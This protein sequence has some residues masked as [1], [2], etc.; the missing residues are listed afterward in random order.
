ALE[1]SAPSGD[2]LR[3]RAK[4][5]LNANQPQA[6]VPLLQRALRTDPHDYASRYHLVLAYRALGQRTEA[7][8]QQRLLDQ[9][10]HDLAKIS[11]LNQEA[12]KRPW[13]ASVRLQLVALCEKLGKREMAEM[14]RQA[15]A[16]CPPAP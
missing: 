11:E 5:Y 12:G 4:L 8:E 1:F 13:D 14:W 3:Q 10:L 16:A 7:D 6:A 9:T 15:A 2:L